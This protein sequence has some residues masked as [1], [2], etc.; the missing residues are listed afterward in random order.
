MHSKH[1]SFHYDQAERLKRQDPL[2]LLKHIGLQPGMVFIDIGS[3]DGFFSLPAAEMIGPNGLIYAVDI[4]QQA[5]ENLKQKFNNNKLANYELKVA[6]AEDT[7]FGENIADIIFLGTVLHD[8][9]DPLK[10]LLN[11]KTML[12]RDGGKL[13]NLDWRQKPM[14]IGPPQSI[15]FSKAK[16]ERL[17]EEAG[18]SLSRS[19]DYDSNFYLIEA[20]IA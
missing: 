13:I 6:K 16:A 3:N 19:Y 15:R 2:A 7:V 4:N 1:S 14:K 5:I 9:E 11:A 20:V 10:V 18:F 8:F 17:I 12:K